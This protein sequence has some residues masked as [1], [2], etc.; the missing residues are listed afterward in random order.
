MIA[1][2]FSPN[3]ARDIVNI[4]LRDNANEDSGRGIL[5]LQVKVSFMWEAVTPRFI[6]R[7]ARVLSRP[8]LKWEGYLS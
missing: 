5:Q 7:K 1:H 3:D 2:I 8:I 4:P 6:Q